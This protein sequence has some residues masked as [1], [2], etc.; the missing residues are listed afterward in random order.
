M[1]VFPIQPAAGSLILGG[2]NLSQQQA[3]FILGFLSTSACHRLALF[4]GCCQLQ[5]ATG[6]CFFGDVF[7]SAHSRRFVFG[8]VVNFSLPQAGFVLGVLAI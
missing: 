5:P 8:G 1:G 2:V 7:N 4:F 6:G 3:G